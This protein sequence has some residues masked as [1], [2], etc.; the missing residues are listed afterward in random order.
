MAVALASAASLSLFAA[1]DGLNNPF[2]PRLSGD[3]AA[4]SAFDCA[5][6][7]PLELPALA[8]PGYH[9]ARLCGTQTAWAEIVIAQITELRLSFPHGVMNVAVDVYS[10]EGEHAGQLNTAEDALELTMSP[11]RWVLAAT[12]EDPEGSYQWEHF[13]ISIEVLE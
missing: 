6:E 7:E 12:P 10:P 4:P 8:V 5:E 1:C 11:G 9:D 2:E 13:T 3:I